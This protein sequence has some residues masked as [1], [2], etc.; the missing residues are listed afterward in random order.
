[1]ENN[2][3]TVRIGA[4]WLATGTAGVEERLVSEVLLVTSPSALKCSFP[5]QQK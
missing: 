4:Q 2:S 1:M 3:T 5:G